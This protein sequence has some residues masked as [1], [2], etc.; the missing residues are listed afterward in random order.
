MR[1]EKSN[2]ILLGDR[3]AYCFQLLEKRKAPLIIEKK[4]ITNVILM[5]YIGEE[6]IFRTIEKVYIVLDYITGSFLYAIHLKRKLNAT[7][8]ASP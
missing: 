8:F 5:L 4:P 6:I 3:V 7:T 1:I 2:K